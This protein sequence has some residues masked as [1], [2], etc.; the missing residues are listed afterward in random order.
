[1]SCFE[2]YL[3]EIH[4]LLE[5]ERK[6]VDIA[7]VYAQNLSV[8]TKLLQKA[9]RR[10]KVRLHIPSPPHRDNPQPNIPPRE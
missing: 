4:D 3:N 6:D 5:S 2:I 8:A 7:N 10:R 1:M 9:L